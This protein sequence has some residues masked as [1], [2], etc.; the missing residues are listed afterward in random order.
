MEENPKLG[1]VM[2]HRAILDEHGYR[3]DEPPFYNQ[4]CVI[5]GREQAAVY[6]DGSS[7]S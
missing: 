1:F 3:M 4:S 5:D 2:V 6:Y 7:E